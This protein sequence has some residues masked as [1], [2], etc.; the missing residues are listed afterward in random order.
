MVLTGITRR[1]LLGL[2]AK[3]AA[4]AFVL[5]VPKAL[6]ESPWVDRAAAQTPPTVQATFTALV[7]AVTT[8][9]DEATAAWIVAE[10][11]K[12]LPPLPQGSPS[13]AVA[14]ILDAYTVS[15]GH[16]VLFVQASPDQR[17]AVLE[18]MVTD[19]SP[20][21]RQVANQAIPFASFAYW[22]DA[23]LG[24]PAEP[25]GPRLPQWDEAGWPGP[26]HGYEDSYRDGSPPGFQAS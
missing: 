14:A 26:S 8:V 15:G 2:T 20:D 1:N 5:S 3:A 13:A 23:S 7:E 6:Y 4:G 17:R 25:G 18:A 19:D 24:E 11:D 21:I 16:H 22:S 12:A 9:P 10:F